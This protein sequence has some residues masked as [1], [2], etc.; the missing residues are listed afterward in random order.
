M[1]RCEMGEGVGWGHLEHLFGAR[2][3]WF[4]WSEGPQG[5]LDGKL[6]LPSGNPESIICP[7]CQAAAC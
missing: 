1:L 2:A 7:G 6:G 3:V 5:A 4:P